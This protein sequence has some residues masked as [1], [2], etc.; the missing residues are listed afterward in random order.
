MQQTGTVK[1]P[2]AG[3]VYAA[4]VPML[5][6]YNHHCFLSHLIDHHE[7][8]I[9]IHNIERDVLWEG[10]YRTSRGKW[11]IPVSATEGAIIWAEMYSS[12]YSTCNWKG[13]LAEASLV[14]RTCSDPST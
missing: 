3:S 9:L 14:A 10:L 6:F 5:Y 7:M 4:R 1:L 2:P 11:D 13:S 12:L 8:I